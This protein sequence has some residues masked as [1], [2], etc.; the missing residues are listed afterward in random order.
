MALDAERTTLLCF[1]PCLVYKRTPTESFKPSK[2][3]CH[4]AN[5]AYEERAATQE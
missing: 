1:M 2:L 5:A 3:R 4:R